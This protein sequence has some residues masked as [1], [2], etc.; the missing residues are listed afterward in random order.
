MP[1]AREVMLEA[2]AEK[3]GKETTQITA[4]RD[5]LMPQQKPDAMSMRDELAIEIL[6]AMIQA[7]T[8]NIQFESHWQPANPVRQTELDKH[9]QRLKNLAI[10]A[11][12][13]AEIV[14]QIRNMNRIELLETGL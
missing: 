3:D 7:R 6:A 9:D 10:S 8:M 13:M 14:I 2:A 12:R 4:P 1:T 5:L 11:Y